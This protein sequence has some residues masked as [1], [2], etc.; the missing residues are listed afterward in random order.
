MTHITEPPKTESLVQMQRGCSVVQISLTCG[1]GREE[2]R[3]AGQRD[4]M[5]SMLDKYHGGGFI[6]TGCGQRFSRQRDGSKHLRAC[7]TSRSGVAE[8]SA[9]VYQGARSA[10]RQASNS[11]GGCD[12]FLEGGNVSGGAIGGEDEDRQMRDLVR[13]EEVGV[14]V[15]CSL[16]C[17]GT[18][19]AEAVHSLLMCL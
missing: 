10:V 1:G 18:A 3:G 16:I 15:C 6:C 17:V 2:D 12:G 14:R 9:P 5:S 19:V 4:A 8:A 13:G 7:S 11:V